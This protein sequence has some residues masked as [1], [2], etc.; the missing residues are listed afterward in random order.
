MDIIKQVKYPVKV[1][2]GGGYPHRVFDLVL[3]AQVI[4]VHPMGL[5]KEY[6]R[7]SCSVTVQDVN[8]GRIV[9]M[10]GLNRMARECQR[11]RVG[12]MVHARG[13]FTLFRHGGDS[14]K[15]LF[16]NEFLDECPDIHDGSVVTRQLVPTSPV[17][18]PV[19]D[20]SYGEL[21]DES[22]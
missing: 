9:N 3:N 17:P 12:D 19:G 4:K 15:Q 16:V 2:G 21:G 11:L 18:G 7:E 20:E 1:N 5:T 13:E 8:D 22:L 14:S 10:T 6:Q